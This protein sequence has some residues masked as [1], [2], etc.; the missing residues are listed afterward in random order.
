MNILH[1]QWLW[2]FN[3]IL[4]AATLFFGAG[5]I[6]HTLTQE[7]FVKYRLRKLVALS[8]NLKRLGASPKATIQEAV[9]KINKQFP[10][11]ELIVLTANR[12]H[13]IP[14]ELS[15]YWRE[16][17]QEAGRMEQVRRVAKNGKNKWRRIEALICLGF[18][19]SDPDV[20]ILENGLDDPDD[21]ISYYS[22]LA[23]AEMKN[24]AA[25]GVLL[26]FLDRESFRGQKIV[27]LLEGFSIDISDQLLNALE[28][29]NPRVRYWALKLLSKFKPENSADRIIS[30][31]TDPSPDV[32]AAACQY[33][34]LMKATES[35]KALLA[36]F[37]DPEWFVRMHAVRSL[38]MLEESKY[39]TQ[40]I[41]LLYTDPSSYVKESAKNAVIHDMKQAL[42]YL[43]HGL[44]EK[45]ELTKRCCVEAFIDS[46]YIPRILDGIL[47]KDRD[48]YQKQFQ[49]LSKL[50]HS[51]IHFGLK[52]ELMNYESMKRQKIIAAIREINSTLA[53]IME[54]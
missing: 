46:N 34:G 23:L 32:R 18:L 47:S 53:E 10:L 24:A 30:L 16:A 14:K 26:E 33:L 2:F 28:S 44:D 3:L 13:F 31:A 40:M 17:F 50:I 49:L 12:E 6:I 39:L 54:R 15:E 7:L 11:N 41:H 22:M 42:P 27:S 48:I 25:A 9:Q 38:S 5:I 29:K 43:E 21:D 51:N 1:P 37:E 20:D 8:E 45:D 19:K 35:E 4:L 52:K 36:R